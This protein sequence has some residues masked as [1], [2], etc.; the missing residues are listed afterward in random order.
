M[1]DRKASASS[2]PSVQSVTT[3]RRLARSAGRRGPPSRPAAAA[4][5]SRSGRPCPTATSMGHRN[6]SSGEP[7]SMS[8]SIAARWR[9]S[10]RCGKYH[11]S[12]VALVGRID[13]DLVHGTLAA[14]ADETAYGRPPARLHQIHLSSRSECAHPALHLD[15]EA[16]FP[17]RAR[18]DM[19]DDRASRISIGGA[20]LALLHRR[21][22]LR[23]D[24][25]RWQDAGAEQ[26]DPRRCPT[27]SMRLVTTPTS[28]CWCGSIAFSSGAR[29]HIEHPTPVGHLAWQNL[30]PA[31]TPTW[32][33]RSICWRCSWRRPRSGQQPLTPAILLVSDGMPTDDYESA[34]G[35]FLEEP[36]AR[37][38]GAA[39]R[40]R[41]RRRSGGA[42][43]FHGVVRPRCAH[44]QQPGATRPDDPL[45]VVARVE[46]G[47]Q[48]SHHPIR[49]FARSTAT[50]SSTRRTSS[51]DREEG[52]STDHISSAA[53]VPTRRPTD[54]RHRS[55]LLTT[56]RVESPATDVRRNEAGRARRRRPRPARRKR[57]SI[58]SA[59]T[60]TPKRSR[61]YFVA[62]PFGD[63]EAVHVTRCTHGLHHRCDRQH[64]SPI[65]IVGLESRPLRSE[66]R[67]P[68]KAN[69]RRQQR[70]PD[71]LR[72]GPTQ[73]LRALVTPRCS[74]SSSRTEI[75]F[76]I[77]SV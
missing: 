60:T 14:L 40:H 59:C 69:S 71:S 13:H 17:H 61:C 35:R 54:G 22:L 10:A 37:P 23:V 68:A 1:Q 65:E 20:A 32:A 66:L 49:S 25:R 19:T 16:I 5:R 38:S 29:W 33:P 7:R 57:G 58:A 50:T 48:P 70:R 8:S 72:T 75:A 77:H 53:S 12:R 30:T 45:G 76:A 62:N 31:A 36:M 43:P 42:A 46:S 47:L 28:H 56:T 9:A 21:R 64:L 67:L 41:P 3:A 63:L 44:R 52:S 74:S 34:L 55:Q 15:E 73:S 11:L 6:R 39:R 51:G 26:F 4:S 24:G 2:M 18:S 27:W